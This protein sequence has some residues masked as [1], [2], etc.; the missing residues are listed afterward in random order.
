MAMH[1]QNFFRQTQGRDGTSHFVVTLSA[2]AFALAVAVVAVTLG[3]CFFMGFMVGRGQNPEKHLEEIAGMLQPAGQ[4]AQAPAA[5]PEDAAQGQDGAAGQGGQDGPGGQDA[6]AQGAEAVTHGNTD[7]TVL[8][9]KE[10]GC[11]IHRHVIVDQP[12]LDG[13][14]VRDCPVV[15]IG[16][17]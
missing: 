8:V 1:L 9:H 16:F 5:K 7:K 6:G 15:F 11:L 4:Q 2:P 17:R 14:C 12:P 10:A 13:S 3:W